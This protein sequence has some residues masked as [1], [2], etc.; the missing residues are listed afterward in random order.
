MSLKE[1][2]SREFANGKVYALEA[3]TGD[4]VAEFDLG[5]PVASSPVLVGRLVIVATEKG[6]IYSLDT[7]NNKIKL[8]ATIEAT[9]SAPLSATDEVV[10]IHTADLTVHPV[11]IETGAK[12]R[13]ISLKR[14]G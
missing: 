8:L 14:P 2:A 9:I 10:Y 11:D 6:E 4:K 5:N 7:S 3:Q 13:T 12:L 1:I